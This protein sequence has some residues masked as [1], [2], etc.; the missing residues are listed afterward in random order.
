M[1]KRG[2]RSLFS[3]MVTDGSLVKVVVVKLMVLELKGMR[4]LHWY[5]TPIAFG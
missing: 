1:R 3:Q 5:S 2:E 4:K